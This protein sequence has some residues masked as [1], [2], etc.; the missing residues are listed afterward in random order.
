MLEYQPQRAR[1]MK[2]VSHPQPIHPPQN[3][4]NGEFAKLASV[5]QFGNEKVTVL[6]KHLSYNGDLNLWCF[7]QSKLFWDDSQKRGL[8]PAIADPLSYTDRILRATSAEFP[9][10]VDIP[11]PEDVVNSLD[12]IS[13]TPP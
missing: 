3:G 4:K 13:P 9:L 7:T 2:G 8:S 11:L 5:P 10:G 1:P 12:W 6:T